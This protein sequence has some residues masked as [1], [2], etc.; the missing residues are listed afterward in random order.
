MT[1]TI[2]G[3]EYRVACGPQE[4]DELLACAQYIDR[5][6]AK[7]RE[8][9]KVLGADRIAVLVALQLAQELF[10]MRNA[11]GVPIADLRRRLR[12]LNDLAGEML[13]PQEKLF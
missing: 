2:M 7:I 8:S 11:D 4:R 10:G 1:V 3:R 12:E 6:M 5:K 9:G 13:A